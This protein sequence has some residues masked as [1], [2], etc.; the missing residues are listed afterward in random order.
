MCDT[1]GCNITSGNEHLIKTGGKH[2]RTPKGR[3]AVSVLRTGNPDG[4][5]GLSSAAGCEA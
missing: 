2:A 5:P 4:F 3:E 1:C